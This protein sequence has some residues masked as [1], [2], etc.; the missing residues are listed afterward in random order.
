MQGPLGSLP[1]TRGAPAPVA[2]W[3]HLVDFPRTSASKRA[4]EV[5]TFL[6]AGVR[7]PTLGP[8]LPTTL[9]G[10]AF[11]AGGVCTCEATTQGRKA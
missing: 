1:R 8:H 4:R 6:P 11:S 9:P 7:G 5:D 2:R 3:R 10:G